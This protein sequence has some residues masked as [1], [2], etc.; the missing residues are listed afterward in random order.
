MIKKLSIIFVLIFLSIASFSQKKE[1]R[2]IEKSFY[3]ALDYIYT[4]DYKKA[5]DILYALD[6]MQLP[7]FLKNSNEY[8]F[9]LDS[10]FISLE[11]VYVKYLIGVCHLETYGDDKTALPYIEYVMQSG[12]SG[13]PTIIYKDLGKLYHLDYQFDKSIYYLQKFIKSTKPNDEYYAYA[14]NLIQVCENA[15]LI[16]K[17]TLFWDIVEMR[18]GVNSNEYDEKNVAVSYDNNT[19][20]IEKVDKTTLTSSIWI[21][22]KELGI[23]TKAKKII[24]P[25]N[26][27]QKNV[28]IEIGG[29]D[30]NQTHL[31]IY[32]RSENKLEAFKVIISDDKVIELIPMKFTF[33]QPND[34][35]F[36]YGKNKNIIYFSS[37][38]AGAKSF[39]ILSVEYKKSGWQS[40]Q[41]LN[42]I[43][44]VF[45]EI[46]PFY[47]RIDKKL[48]YSSTGNNTMGG[49]DIFSVEIN[50]KNILS[51]IQNIGFAINT[52]KDNTSVQIPISTRTIYFTSG[53]KNSINLRNIYHTDLAPSIPFTLLNGTFLAGNPPK[54]TDVTVTVIET[55][56]KTKVKYAFGAK[57]NSGKYYII[58]KPDKTYQLIFKAKGYIPQLVTVKIPSQKYF[59]QIFQ[60]ITLIP[61]SKGTK[62]TIQELNVENNFTDEFTGN[63]NLAENNKEL[64]NIINENVQDNTILDTISNYS[65]KNKTKEVKNY[66]ALFNLIENTI[67]NSDTATINQLF[68]KG[69]NT[70]YYSITYN[71]TIDSSKN[72]I[73]ID[74]DT[75][76]TPP[77]VNALEDF[78]SQ[79]LNKILGAK[80][81]IGNQDY[82]STLDKNLIF[83]YE[84]IMNED[85]VNVPPKYFSVLNDVID[86]INSDPYLH[87]IIEGVSQN[88]YTST[89]EEMR[90]T[91]NKALIVSNYLRSHNAKSKIF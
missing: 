54:P 49:F 32:K 24:F 44:T 65:N 70:K 28:S 72:F 14:K 56:S 9:Y 31:V 76:F 27:L 50:K 10:Q 11:K 69:E 58:F 35:R 81:I 74:G 2:L 51:N 37:K 29:M 20:Y 86:L 38:R 8:Q 30:F 64:I 12:Y 39:D 5:L 47:D 73:I 63:S 79:H 88:K 34:G 75:I 22:H 71:S 23:W 52:V 33:L 43:N 42:K 60:K 91:K 59:Y 87:V 80:T 6:S 1:K 57:N 46:D 53:Q 4:E 78:D 25:S 90:K 15:K 61:L 89:S 84:M 3:K 18:G 48:Y 40:P 82:S 7:Q 66:D 26:F 85:A 36:C 17:D 62:N 16:T 67:V 83:K 55:A 21:S 77:P 13:T 41:K 45:D 19:I 68:E